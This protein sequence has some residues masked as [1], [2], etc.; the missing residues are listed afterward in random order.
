MKM[1]VVIKHPVKLIMRGLAVPAK[2]GV[3]AD[4]VAIVQPGFPHVTTKITLL[5]GSWELHQYLTQI[6]VVDDRSHRRG[7]PKDVMSA[8]LKIYDE[9]AKIAPTQDPNV[10]KDPTAYSWDDH[11]RL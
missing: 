4:L 3:P 2:N 10:R 1:K 7:F 11:H 8:L 6:L 9:H 5:W